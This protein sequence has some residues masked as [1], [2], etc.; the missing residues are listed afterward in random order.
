MSVQFRRRVETKIDTLEI[1]GLDV[2]FRVVKT[3]KKEPNTCELT[4]YNLGSKARDQIAQSDKPIVQIKAG[5]AGLKTVGEVVV[6]LVFLGNV[7][8]ADSGKE[9]RDW[10]TSLESGDG[11]RATRFS[12]I[13]K[14]FASGTSLATVMN[15]VAKSMEVGIGNAA[16][17]A[18]SG[19]LLE[20]GQEFLNS[21]TLSGQAS[22]EMDRIV[23]SSGLEWSIQD[24]AFQLLDPG[25]PLEDVSIVL[26]DKTGLIGSPTVG[27]DGIIRLRTLLNSDIVPGRQLEIDSKTLQRGSSVEGLGVLGDVNLG[28]DEAL[29]T[30]TLS[31]FRAERVEY[32]GSFDN[33]FYC[34]IEATEL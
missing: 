10:V 13:N 25:K 31:R 6:G 7:R 21:V 11:E 34:D 20:A 32:L 33:D 22:K 16:K 14:S 23:K 15:E 12:R 24:G 8:D 27:N 18:A 30:A 3:L 28:L 1:L 4:V 2:S 9:G 19:S 5:Y 17:K 26:S 29:G